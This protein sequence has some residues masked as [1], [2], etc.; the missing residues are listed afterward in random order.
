[1]FMNA[2]IAMSWA[3]FESGDRSLEG[4]IGLN[5]ARSTA[6]LTAAFTKLDGLASSIIF[7]TV[8][9]PLKP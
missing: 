3:G 6:D 8:S 2:T 7:A 4:G 1:M 9:N 5:F